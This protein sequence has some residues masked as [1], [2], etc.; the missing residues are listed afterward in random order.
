MAP[1]IWLQNRVDLFLA[2]G[3]LILYYVYILKCADETLYTGWTTDLKRRASEHNGTKKGSKYTR[4]RRPVNIVYVE[5]KETKQEAMKREAEIKK[6]KR[7]EKLDL[8]K[9][10]QA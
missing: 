2:E 9:G 7:D 5:E 4:A 10:K 1:E 8:I 3:R 6:L